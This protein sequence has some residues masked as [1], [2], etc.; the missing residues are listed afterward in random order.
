MA[1]NSR[2][3]GKTGELEACQTLRDLFGWTSRRS[4]QFS[5]WSP[6]NDSPDI[7][8][9]Q[10]PSAFWEIKRQERLNIPKA[11]QVAVAQAGRKLALLMHRQSRGEWLLTIR[12]SDLPR[13]CHAYEIA[14]HDSVVTPPLPNQNA[15]DS[16]RSKEPAGAAR[17]V[18]N[19]GRAGSHKADRLR[20]ANDE[21]DVA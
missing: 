7:I 14:I 1:V 13:L 8:V 21:G 11:M 16:P 2:R 3:K 10:T 19:R 12:L 20:R 9:D 4:Q 15:D 5:G 6:T 17:P 18:P